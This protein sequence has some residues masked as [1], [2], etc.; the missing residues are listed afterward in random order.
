VESELTLEQVK[1][2]LD[3]WDNVEVGMLVTGYDRSYQR[4]I[5]KVT[6]KTRYGK[7]PTLDWSFDVVVI[8]FDGMPCGDGEGS[9]AVPAHQYRQATEDELNEEKVRQMF[10]RGKRAGVDGHP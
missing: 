1:V 2:R 10:L 6:G 7:D 9:Y 4:S 5:Y 8:S 3:N